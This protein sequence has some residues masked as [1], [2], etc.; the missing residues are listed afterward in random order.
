METN[1]AGLL[2]ER[3]IEK[4]VFGAGIVFLLLAAIRVCNAVMKTKTVPA[5]SPAQW[6]QIA[7]DDKQTDAL[8]KQIEQIAS[9]AKG[10][11]GVAAEVLETGESV[12]LNPHEHFPMQSVYKL[13]IGMA[14]LAQVDNGKLRLAQDRKS[15]V[16]GERG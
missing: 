11:V 2:K 14:V 4:K 1:Q 8:Q 7:A 10:H 9:A 15:V 16:L 3:S 5:D 6:E 13:P 12:S